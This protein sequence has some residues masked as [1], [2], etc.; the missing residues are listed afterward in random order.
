MTLSF[1]FWVLYCRMQKVEEALIAPLVHTSYFDI[2]IPRLSIGCLGLEVLDS[3][4]QIELGYCQRGSLRSESCS[5]EGLA[6]SGVPFY[7]LSL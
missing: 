6:S 7:S 3:V 2:E 4:L 5:K 1:D